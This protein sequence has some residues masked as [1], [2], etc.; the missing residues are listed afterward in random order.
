MSWI[1]RTDRTESDLDYYGR[2][3]DRAVSAGKTL[4]FRRGGG[5]SLGV[6]GENYGPEAH[7]YRLSGAPRWWGPGCVQQ[8]L[9]QGGWTEW[10][11]NA[12]KEP[13][14]KAQ[15][16]LFVATAPEGESQDLARG[17]I[18]AY[19]CGAF[20]LTV[21]QWTKTREAVTV[22]PWAASTSAAKSSTQ[23]AWPKQVQ[24]ERKVIDLEN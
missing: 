10:K 1:K 4:V 16:W 9:E 17:D 22:T 11:P 3:T 7:Q 6:L 19:E 12:L 14:N 2:A 21:R 20:T 18:L 24:E 8:F 23:W 5:A 15:G 13:R